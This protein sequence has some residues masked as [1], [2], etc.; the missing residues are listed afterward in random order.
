MSIRNGLAWGVF[1]F[2]ALLLAAG[3]VPFGMRLDLEQTTWW[4]IQ[5]V[6]FL[7]LIIITGASLYLDGISV[8]VRE[9]LVQRTRAILAITAVGS[10]PLCLMAIGHPSLSVVGLVAGFVPLV[11][12]KGLTSIRC[13]RC[14]G[15]LGVRTALALAS[16]GMGGHTRIDYCESCYVLLDE[17]RKGPRRQPVED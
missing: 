16:W 15:Y 7:G 13:P 2:G 14:K 11:A 6:M 4:R 9:Y 5:M 8:T 1:G 10:L 12:I 17:P 3:L